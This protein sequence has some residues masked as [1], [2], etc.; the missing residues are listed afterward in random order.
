VIFLASTTLPIPL[1]LSLL[2]KVKYAKQS[3]AEE[4]GKEERDNEAG[5]DLKSEAPYREA[6]KDTN[7]VFKCESS[8]EDEEHEGT[9]T[10]DGSFAMALSIDDCGSC[11]VIFDL[12][13]I[14]LPFN[15]LTLT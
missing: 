3:A 9:V 10:V 11:K 12:Q 6:V 7:D 1:L 14:P 5:F 13:S 15:L 2:G 4:Q 8:S